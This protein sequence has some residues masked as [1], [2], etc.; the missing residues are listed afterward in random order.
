LAERSFLIGEHVHRSRLYTQINSVPGFWVTS[1]MIG[2]AGQ[3]LSEQNIP[4][5]VRSMARFAMNDLQVI[6]R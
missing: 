6:V 4:I 2:Q 5:D 1:L 3:A